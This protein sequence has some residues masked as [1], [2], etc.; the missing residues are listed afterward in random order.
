MKLKQIAITLE[1]KI[2]LIPKKLKEYKSVGKKTY[3]LYTVSFLIFR[4]TV[5]ILTKFK[6]KTQK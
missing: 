2:L 4:V 5:V 1:A 3:I 6:P